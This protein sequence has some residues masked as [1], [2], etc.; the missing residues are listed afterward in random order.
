MMAVAE[1]DTLLAQIGET[2][3]RLRTKGLTHADQETLTTPPREHGYGRLELIWSEE[4]DSQDPVATK[5][6]RNRAR[7]LYKEIQEA[8]EHL[9]LACVLT[10]TPTECIKKRDAIKDLCRLRNY[11]QYH[12]KLSQDAEDWFKSTAVE[13]DFANSQGY[14]NFMDALFS[15]NRDTEIPQGIYPGHLEV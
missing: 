11:Q 10:I 5:W 12:L 3:K 4:R 14:L 6:R 8:D 7:N 13:Y 2:S 1:S 15:P 9:F